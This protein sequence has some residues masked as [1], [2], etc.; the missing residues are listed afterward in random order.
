MGLEGKQAK[1]PVQQ[2]I[3]LSICRVAEPIALS[4]VFPYLPEMIESF[5]IPKKD[6]SK[7]AGI[8]S[9]V[10]SLSQAVTGVFWGRAADRFG[11]KPVIMC[12][13]LGIMIT[14]LLFGFSKTLSWAIASRSIAGACNGNVGTMRTMVAELVPQKELQPRAFSVM[15]LVWTI[16]SIFGPAFGGALAKPATRHP[17][18][19][20]KSRF[21]QQYPFALPNMIASLFFLVGLSVGIL[22]LQETL[23]SKKHRRDYGRALGSLLL[24]P[25][26]RKKVKSFLQEEQSSPMMK[27]SRDSSAA[28]LTQD[29]DHQPAPLRLAPPTYREVFWYQSN[30]NLLTYALLAMHSIAYDQL[31]PIFMHYP[32]RTDRSS[33]PDQQLPFKFT[34]GFGIDSDRIGLI[35]MLYAVIGCFI[36]FAI[37]PV[38]ARRWGVLNCL[39]LVV[40]MFPLV[41]VATPFT[42]LLPTQ[43]SQQIG[44]FVIMMFKCWAAIFAFPCTTILLTNSA[45]SLRILGT[46]N[47]FAVSLSALGRA[48]GPA[49]GGWTFTLGVKIGYGILPWWTL[50][51][52]AIVAAFPV[53]WLVEMDGFG[54]TA[55][56]DTQE[57]E[58][59]ARYTDEVDVEDGGVTSDIR[60]APKYHDDVDQR[61]DSATDH[62][63]LGNGVQNHKVL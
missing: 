12:G 17:G 45:K 57:I 61:D 52:C 35:F 58:D 5:D 16:G 60:R 14:S 11:R 53:W 22:F 30:L 49:T 48:A 51:A 4:S 44:L 63:V 23:E 10:F 6:V 42:A 31:L 18:L 62:K 3:I 56:D 46:L 19:F 24:R 2:L 21:F 36:Q 41:Y 29:G 37:F 32:R 8:A 13:M 20:G 26:Q 33:D 34:G 27:H 7:W 9:A 40:I 43:I 38:L 47:G 15:P 55:K 50:A 25:F 39:K 59:E 54:G 28:T 1:L